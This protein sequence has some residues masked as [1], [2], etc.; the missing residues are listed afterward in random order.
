MILD[1]IKIYVKS[2]QKIKNMYLIFRRL[3][4]PIVNPLKF[5]NIYKVFNY[6]KDIAA[7]RRAGGSVKLTELWPILNEKTAETKIDPQYFY[8][9][10]WGFS[11]IKE[12]EVKEHV[13]IGSQVNMVGLLTTITKI[14]FIDIR[15]L[16]L[17]INNY[18]GINGSILELPLLD[19]SVKSLSCMHVIEHIGLGRY[20]DP[21]DPKGSIKA[22]NEIQR[23]L[24]KNGK[25][26]ITVPIGR[27]RTQFNS[28][29]IFN[30]NNFISMFSECNLNEMAYVNTVGEYIEKIEPRNVSIDEHDAGNDYGL[31]LFVFEKK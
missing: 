1:S 23:V 22:V 2:H 12:S 7:Y 6:I 16:V 17:N 11:K 19:G 27:E 30:V 10:I 24:E 29:R 28:Q 31:G 20:G 5:F 26:Y 9:A 18:E 8:Q 14:K 25:A 15:P 21:I 13:D 3:I 4:F